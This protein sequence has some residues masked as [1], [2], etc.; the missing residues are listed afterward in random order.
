MQEIDAKNTTIMIQW[1]PNNHDTINNVRRCKLQ[2]LANKVPA[3]SVIYMD[4]R[5]SHSAQHRTAQHSTADVSQHWANWVVA[6]MTELIQYVEYGLKHTHA[7]MTVPVPPS[8]QHA[9]PGLSLW[10]AAFG[11]L[12]SPIELNV[13]PCADGVDVESF[14]S[15]APGDSYRSAVLFSND[16]KNMRHANPPV[17]ELRVSDSQRQRILLAQETHIVYIIELW[18]DWNDVLCKDSKTGCY[19]HFLTSCLCY[20]FATENGL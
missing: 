12:S 7:L 18:M 19:T 14:E 4:S 10:T 16:K 5:I 1:H 15:P 3:V 2:Q 8:L 13:H 11:K 17:N 9:W 6:V 20:L